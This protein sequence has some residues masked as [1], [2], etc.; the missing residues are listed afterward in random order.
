M[1][2]IARILVTVEIVCCIG[3]EGGNSRHN[4]ISVLSLNFPLT[5]TAARS[6]ARPAGRGLPLSNGMSLPRVMWDFPAAAAA[7]ASTDDAGQS[8]LAFWQAGGRFISFLISGPFPRSS[9]SAGQDERSTCR[10][11]DF[12][13][14]VCAQLC[15]NEVEMTKFRTFLR[16]VRA[17]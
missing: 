16:S 15:E 9:Q 13:S 5:F 8:M 1:H 14:E 10:I 12:R 2:R 17:F 11:G 4:F 7:A 3:R 6:L